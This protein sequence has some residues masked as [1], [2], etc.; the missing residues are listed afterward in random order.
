MFW[1]LVIGGARMPFHSTCLSAPVSDGIC[2]WAELQDYA[3]KMACGP[4]QKTL[5]L[6]SEQNKNGRRQEK[7]CL[8]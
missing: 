6:G 1:N 7:G 4:S 5:G 2:R 3:S 8:F